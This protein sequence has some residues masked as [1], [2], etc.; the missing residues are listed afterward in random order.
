MAFSVQLILRLEVSNVINRVTNRKLSAS[1]FIFIERNSKTLKLIDLRK[2]SGNIFR[3]KHT[4]VHRQIISRSN[5][6][7]AYLHANILLPFVISILYKVRLFEITGFY[8]GQGKG[9]CV[10]KKIGEI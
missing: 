3:G 7:F 9:V 4:T 6:S 2:K 1:V 5:R 8:T 10:G